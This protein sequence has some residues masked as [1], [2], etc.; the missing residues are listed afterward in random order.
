M[1]EEKIS[2]QILGLD[3]HFLKNIATEK[4]K[5]KRTKIYA[6]NPSRTSLWPDLD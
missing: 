1:P 6:L 5:D 4:L 3:F 2:D